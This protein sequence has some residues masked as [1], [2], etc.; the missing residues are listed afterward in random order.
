MKSN[1]IQ[2]IEQYQFKNKTIIENNPR[3]GI[4]F[5]WSSDAYE[6]EFNR[7]FIADL[8]QTLK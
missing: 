8:K 2:L 3:L 6:L 1:I 7:R 5:D 4:E